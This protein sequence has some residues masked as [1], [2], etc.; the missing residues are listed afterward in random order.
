MTIQL[1]PIPKSTRLCVIEIE[2]NDFS[3]MVEGFRRLRDDWRVES[4]QVKVVN[5]FY[6]A[7]NMDVRFKDIDLPQ[8]DSERRYGLAAYSVVVYAAGGNRMTEGVFRD[9]RR[10]MPRKAGIVSLS[11][12]LKFSGTVIRKEMRPS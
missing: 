12:R 11:P 2:K 9:L 7:I 4:L 3:A 8:E 6:Q 10:L 1:S 5:S